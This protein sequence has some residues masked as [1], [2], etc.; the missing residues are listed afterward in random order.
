MRARRASRSFEG[1]GEA[2]D[3]HHLAGRGDVEGRLAGR[4]WPL[5]LPRPTTRRRARSFMSMARRQRTRAVEVDGALVAEVERV[6]DD[7]REEVV[8]AVMAWMSPVKWRLM[9][10]ARAR[11]SAAAAG[12]AALDAEHGPERGLAQ[13]GDG[14]HGRA[15]EAHREGH[16]GGGLALARGRRVDRR[17][18]HEPC[19]FC[20]PRRS[21]WPRLSA[22]S[23]PRAAC[24][25]RRAAPRRSS[26]GARARGGRARAR[27][28]RC[29]TS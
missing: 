1:G 5:P 9:S 17:D 4:R 26:A 7:R 21:E 11:A 19:V 23:Q 3:G 20:P 16:R 2:E 28:A 24:A 14:A 6:V 29:R 22:R 8:R 18:E 12:A 27:G 13:G 25:D 10:A 15:C